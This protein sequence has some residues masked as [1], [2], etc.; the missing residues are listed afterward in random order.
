MIDEREDGIRDAIQKFIALLPDDE[1]FNV[2]I[3]YGRDRKFRSVCVK[4]KVRP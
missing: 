2:D 4:R 3:H 1:C